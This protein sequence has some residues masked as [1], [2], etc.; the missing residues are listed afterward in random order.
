[1]IYSMYLGTL[2]KGQKQIV[3]NKERMMKKTIS[4]V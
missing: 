2:A 1:M 3:R 4:E